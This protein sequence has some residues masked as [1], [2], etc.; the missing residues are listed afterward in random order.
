[1]SKTES[2]PAYW[3]NWDVCNL[4][5]NALILNAATL[6]RLKREYDSVYMGLEFELCLN[7]HML[8]LWIR[9]FNDDPA[10]LFVSCRAKLEL[11]IDELLHAS[12][13]LNCI[14]RISFSFNTIILALAKY[15]QVASIKCLTI[16]PET[17]I[18]I[19][20]SQVWTI[21]EGYLVWVFAVGTTVDEDRMFGRH[22]FPMK[23]RC[24]DVIRRMIRALRAGWKEEQGM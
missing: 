3:D 22:K 9:F 18:G 17:S 8:S 6:M 1:M 20:Y 24:S 23:L 7:F 19:I 12:L 21:C 13:L 10:L 11:Q 2:T 15:R 14:R 4:V 5:Y 16:V